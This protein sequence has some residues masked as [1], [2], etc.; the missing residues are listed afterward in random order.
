MI[1]LSR[2]SRAYR[3]GEG[4]CS[5]APWSLKNAEAEG[6]RWACYNYSIRLYIHRIPPKEDL[7]P[8]RVRRTQIN[9]RRRTSD[10]EKGSYMR[11]TDSGF[12]RNGS[13][14]DHLKPS[15]FVEVT[16]MSNLFG[17]DT[18]ARANEQAP[19][20]TNERASGIESKG[21][22][23][24]YIHILPYKHMD[25]ASLDVMCLSS[26]ARRDRFEPNRH[27][28]STRPKPWARVVGAHRELN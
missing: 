18:D 10:G 13:L 6:P 12:V 7:D 28:H 26:L 23:Y 4:S 5:L 15:P 1:F 9:G 17:V 20:P 11:S 14:N 24:T 25:S 19:T 8:R 3:G 21:R 27:T 16:R 22:V 2:H